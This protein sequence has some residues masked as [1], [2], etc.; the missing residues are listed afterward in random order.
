MR[1]SQRLL[2]PLVKSKDFALSLAESSKIS[3]MAIASHVAKSP[4]HKGCLAAKGLLGGQELL[5]VKGSL[6]LMFPS[7]IRMVRRER[8]GVNGTHDAVTSD[9]D[10]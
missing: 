8:G 10:T 6:Q 7:R 2:V 9:R 5:A 1:H 3:A 4:G